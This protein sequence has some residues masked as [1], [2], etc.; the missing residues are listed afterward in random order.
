MTYTY[1]AVKLH[2]KLGKIVIWIFL[3]P[4]SLYA[5]YDCLKNLDFSGRNSDKIMSMLFAY[6]LHLKKGQVQK[7]MHN[8]FK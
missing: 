3:G 6:V 2:G 7:P 5:A 8:L 1:C 4:Y